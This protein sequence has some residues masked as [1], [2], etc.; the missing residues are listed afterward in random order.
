MLALVSGAQFM[1]ILDLAIV[2]VALTAIQSD[3]AVSQ[4][5]LQWVVIGYGLALGGF[6]LLGG[7]LADVLGRRRVL[8]AGLAIFAAAPSGAGLSGS[9]GVLVACRVVQGLGGALV[10]PAA[11]SILTTTFAEGPA[12]NR[13]LGV[14]GAVSGTAATVGLIAG[15]ALD[16]RARVGVGLPHQRADRCRARRRPAAAR[17][18]RTAS[19]RG[20]RSTSPVRR[21]SPPA[22]CSSC[23]RSTAAST[24]AGSTPSTLLPAR[25]RRR[26][27][28]AAFVL[29]EHRSRRRWCRCRRSATG[30]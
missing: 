20:R 9:L 11:L 30:R 12:R 4:S 22:W 2:N 24:T 26:C 27:C 8:I 5:D 14:F 29:V 23:T 16:D 1:I 3:F 15:G 28:S 25:R 7:R 10:S 18:R 6:L 17:A 19:R 21:P 13:A